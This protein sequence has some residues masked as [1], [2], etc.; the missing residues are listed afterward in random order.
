MLEKE[1]GLIPLVYIFE[2]IMQGLKRWYQL[3]QYSDHSLELV[4]LV[5]QR[6]KGQGLPWWCSG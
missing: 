5:T 2:G 4:E 1:K 3:V 6:M